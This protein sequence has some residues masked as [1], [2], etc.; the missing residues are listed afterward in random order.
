MDNHNHLLDDH[1]SVVHPA[2]ISHAS[3]LPRELRLSSRGDVYGHADCVHCALREEVVLIGSCRN[4]W[5][6][7][8]LGLGAG[9]GGHG[10]DVGMG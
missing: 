9:V 6:V 5:F 3:V 1:I 4:T 8:L 7:V 10:Y 2:G